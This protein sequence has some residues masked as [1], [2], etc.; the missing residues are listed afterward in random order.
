MHGSKRKKKD[1]DD[2]YSKIRERDMKGQPG[3]EI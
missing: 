2:G 3:T 1:K